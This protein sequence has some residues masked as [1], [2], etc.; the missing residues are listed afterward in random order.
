MDTWQGDK[1]DKRKEGQNKSRP[2]GRQAGRQIG[3]AERKSM[4]GE[5]KRAQLKQKCVVDVRGRSGVTG[6]YSWEPRT[7][8]V[9]LNALRDSRRFVDSFVTT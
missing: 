3:K 6:V 7:F 1:R 2:V 5:A 9:C 8:A 4:T